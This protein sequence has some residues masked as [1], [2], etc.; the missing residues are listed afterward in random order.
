L[1]SYVCAT[2]SIPIALALHLKGFSMGSLMVFL[3]SGPATNIA[4]ISVAVK[5]IGKKSTLIYIGS[6]AFCSIVSGLLFDMMFPGLSVEQSLSSSMHMIPHSIEVL[7]AIFLLV[8]LA[9]SIRLN[10]FISSKELDIS[11]NAVFF[12]KGMTCNNCVSSVQKT[13]DKIEGVTVLNIDLQSGKI[14]LDCSDDNVDIV[15]KAIIDLGYEI[16][17]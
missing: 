11:A 5:Q 12:I 3:M 6:I 16:K 2:A 1:P 4:T 13:I 9:N 14:E 10:Y 7:S 8:I 15:K 17:E